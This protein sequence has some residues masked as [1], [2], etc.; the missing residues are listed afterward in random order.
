M[1]KQ[2]TAQARKINLLGALE[3]LD[4]LVRRSPSGAGY[5][6]SST[7]QAVR[8]AIDRAYRRR[9]LKAIEPREDQ[10]SI[11]EALQTA[12][13]AVHMNRSAVDPAMREEAEKKLRAVLEG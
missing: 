7:E 6:G 4:E 11:Y 9:R 13:L 3:L 5:V 1:Q 8:S 10:S 12:L 2:T